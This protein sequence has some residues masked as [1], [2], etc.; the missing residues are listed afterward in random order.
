[1]N[2]TLLVSESNGVEDL[3]RIV[4][5][6]HQ[7][8]TSPQTVRQCLFAERIGAHQAAVD[9]VGTLQRQDVRVLPSGG[10]AYLVAKVFLRFSIESICVRDF[11]RDS[12]TFQRIQGT[13]DDSERPLTKFSLN[14]VLAEA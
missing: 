7:R 11:E 3:L 5:R 6:S 12:Q 13:I 4:D 1:M 10:R 2:H 8:Q 9:V 14:T